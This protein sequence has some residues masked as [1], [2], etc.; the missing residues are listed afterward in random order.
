MTDI[1]INILIFCGILL[2]I[3]LTV[4]AIFGAMILFDIRRTTREVSDKVRALAA[5][6]DIATLLIGG[7]SG[8]GKRI[9]NKMGLNGS[10]FAPF[11]AGLKKGLQVLLKK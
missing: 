6:F 1:L 11:I 5:I 3:A 8:T 10:G 4:G 2:L 7:L 9:K